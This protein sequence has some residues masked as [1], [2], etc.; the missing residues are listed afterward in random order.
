[1]K[2]VHVFDCDITKIL[3]LTNIL[4]LK[5]EKILL[6]SL[7]AKE[8]DDRV[9]FDLLS[10]L[11]SLIASGKFCLKTTNFLEQWSK[12]ALSVYLIF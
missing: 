10:L 12:E 4:K 11:S 6:R 3:F 9:N 7:L 2:K 8:S 5:S 1:M